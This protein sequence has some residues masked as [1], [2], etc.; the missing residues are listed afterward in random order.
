M[1]G[2]ELL[3]GLLFGSIGFGYALYGRRQRHLVALLAGLALIG[4]PYVVESTW[5]MLAVGSLLLALPF[6]LRR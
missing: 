6:V 3:W 1:G 4:L 2:S 5:P